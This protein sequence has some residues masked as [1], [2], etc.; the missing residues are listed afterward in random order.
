MTCPR[1]VWE[2]Q[3]L[4]CNGLNTDRRHLPPLPLNP[5]N[6]SGS[7]Q[8]AQTSASSTRK[9][10]RWSS[11]NPAPSPPPYP[12][13]LI[14]GNAAEMPCRRQLHASPSQLHPWL[15][16]GPSMRKERL[17]EAAVPGAVVVLLPLCR[18]PDPACDSDTTRAT[19]QSQPPPLASL[20]DIRGF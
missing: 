8:S 17:K 6:I 9:Q 19:G 15:H 13:L 3:E 16:R 1:S 12:W 14:T 2:H 11:Y 18:V 20:Q 10:P 7:G 4:L 5:G